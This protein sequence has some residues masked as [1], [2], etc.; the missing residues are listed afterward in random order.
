MDV[1]YLLSVS[2]IIITVNV[3]LKRC[4]VTNA[5]SVYVYNLICIGIPTPFRILQYTISID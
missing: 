5:T 1:N 3:V 2:N 4:G